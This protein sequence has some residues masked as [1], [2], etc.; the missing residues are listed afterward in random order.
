MNSHCSA[1]TWTGLPLALRG[2][3]HAAVMVALAL[4]GAGCEDRAIGRA[5]DV[6]ADAGP[7]QAVYNAQA[8]ECPSRV[9]I[10]PARDPTVARLID[11]GPYCTGECSKDGDCDGQ[12]RG[13]GNPTGCKLGFACAVAFEVGPLCCKKLC[14][15]KDYLDLTQAMRLQTP[16]SCSKAAG[17]TC[18]NL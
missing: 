18:Q 11:T 12:T 1:K 3:Q 9:C 16:A 5:C 8:L 17:S 2:T 15:C 4:A 6:Q 10:K 13:T 7:L 14:I